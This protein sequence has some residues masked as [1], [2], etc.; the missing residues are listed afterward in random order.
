MSFF[1]ESGV[2]L[3][4]TRRLPITQRQATNVGVETYQLRLV[5][6]SGCCRIGDGAQPRRQPMR[7]CL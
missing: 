6:N 7:I 3:G 5:A 2:T 1:P 4:S